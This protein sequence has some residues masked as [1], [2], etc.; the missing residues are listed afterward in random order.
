MLLQRLFIGAIALL[1]LAF[2]WR[3]RDSVGMEALTRSTSHKPLDIKF[4]NGTVRQSVA[5][6]APRTAPDPSVGTGLRKCKK[7]PT[8]VYTDGPCPAGT[9]QQALRGGTVTVVDGQAPAA[10]PAAPAEPGT[11][12]RVG[13]RPRGALGEVLDRSAEQPTLSQQRMEQVVNR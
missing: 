13:N 10:A 1:V 11:A 5:S 7:G 3:Q 8:V 9:Q 2:A 6:S 12:Q 4:D